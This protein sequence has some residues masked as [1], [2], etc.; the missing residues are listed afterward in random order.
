[1]TAGALFSLVQT[2]VLVPPALV[3]AVPHTDPLEARYPK[4]HEYG[5]FFIWPPSYQRQSLTIVIDSELQTGF[6]LSN[7][8]PMVSILK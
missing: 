3:C 2:P 4:A 6:S 5:L 7:L 1:M 8:M